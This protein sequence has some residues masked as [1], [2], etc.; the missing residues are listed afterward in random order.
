MPTYESMRAGYRALW[1]RMAILPG[2]RAAAESAAKR[3][4]AGKAR[5]QAIETATGVPWIFVGLTH[6]RESSLNF[7][8]YLGNGQALNKKTTIVPKGR[9]PFPSFEEGARDALLLHNLDAI[10][11][12]PLERLAYELERWNGFGYLGKINS[13]YLWGGSTLQQPGKYIRDHVFDPTVM[14][15][16][17]GC[18]TVL[19][20]MASFD[21]DAAA[22]QAAEKPQDSPKSSPAPVQPPHPQSAP[23]SQSGGWLT[24]IVRI[25]A[26]I[27]KRKG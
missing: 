20:A 27:F 11:E 14:D 2:K 18:L 15:E 12:W 7:S 3:I 5:Y 8:T 6:L 25:I 19:A 21:A 10:K 16:Q 17:L 24:A 22:L 9:G 1:S 26:S 4:I 13:P 23:A